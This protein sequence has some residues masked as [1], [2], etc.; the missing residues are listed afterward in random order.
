MK[1]P[2]VQRIIDVFRERG[3]ESY[4]A[5]AV[6]QLEHAIQAALLAEQNDAPASLVVAAL[7]HD[8]GHILGDLPLP[9]SE[10]ENY[11]DQ[12]ESRAYAWL[13]EHFGAAVADPVRLHVAAKRYLCTVDPGYADYLSPTSLKSFHDQGGV[14]SPEELKQ[15]ES[16]AFFEDAVR[17][18]RWD[19]EAKRSDM[20][21]PSMESFEALLESSLQVT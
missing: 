17:L 8:I 7:L 15:F 2:V 20:Q 3:S 1:S 13:K 12:H 18:R 4:G 19:D 10:E 14:M 16:E 5:E 6:T 9:A 21:L 11:D